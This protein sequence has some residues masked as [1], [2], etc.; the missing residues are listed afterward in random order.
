MKRHH[1]LTLIVIGAGLACWHYGPLIDD[2]GVPDSAESKKQA[3]V[4]GTEPSPEKPG[5]ESDSTESGSDSAEKA[6][7]ESDDVPLEEKAL[8]ERVPRNEQLYF[9]KFRDRGGF[10]QQLRAGDRFDLHATYTVGEAPEPLH[11]WLVDA[12]TATD[13][14]PPGASERI[15]TTL[16]QNVSILAVRP[17]PETGDNGVSLG[18]SVTPEEHRL[19]TLA[20]SVGQLSVHGRHPMFVKIDPVSIST[21]DEVLGQ[22]DDIREH[23][24][25]RCRAEP[26]D[27]AEDGSGQENEDADTNGLADSRSDA[28]S[29]PL[30]ARI[31]AL[32]CCEGLRAVYVATD[33]PPDVYD[34]GDHVDINAR[35]PIDKDGNVITSDAEQAHDYNAT[36]LLQHVNVLSSV[37]TETSRGLV[38]ALSAREARLVR[39]AK[40]NGLLSFGLRHPDDENL[41]DADDLGTRP[42][43]K[44]FQSITDAFFDSPIRPPDLPDSSCCR[45]NEPCCPEGDSEK[46]IEIIRG[47]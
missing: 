22:L 34:C 32:T 43:G 15:L 6:E 2:V 44:T 46:S 45:N 24:Q 10:Y 23:R 33:I 27:H 11:T 20:R 42:Y 9:L 5:E 28:C 26:S 36:P 16:L 39:H 25:E 14:D 29:R 30:L 13:E 21:I 35:F 37:S 19:I 3:L 17:H 8:A 12:T 18:T 1:V 7:E 4:E 31:D 41:D 47:D 38:L 40:M